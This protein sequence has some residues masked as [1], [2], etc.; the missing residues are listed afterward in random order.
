MGGDQEGAVL[1]GSR[2]SLCLKDRQRH[3]TGLARVYKRGLVLL[4]NDLTMV[5]EGRGC[6]YLLCVLLMCGLDIAQECATK[7]TTTIAQS[8]TIHTHCS[9]GTQSSELAWFGREWGSV[10]HYFR[11]K[12]PRGGII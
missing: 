4:V 5:L 6:R 7:R 8:T 12:N 2:N 10:G 3:C 9:E 1:T 11:D